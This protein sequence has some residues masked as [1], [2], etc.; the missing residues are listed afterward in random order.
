MPLQEV[1]IAITPRYTLTRRSSDYSVSINRVTLPHRHGTKGKYRCNVTFSSIL[2]FLSFPFLL[3][4]GF[5]S[6]LFF[7]S[8]WAKFP[9]IFSLSRPN[10]RS[11]ELYYFIEWRF[12]V[13]RRVV[14]CVAECGLLQNPGS[15]LHRRSGWSRNQIQFR[16][17]ITVSN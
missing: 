11:S 9:S 6:A 15:K 14:C 5:F 2:P 13:D 7:L 1:F 4:S 10:N 16:C 3:S 12:V 17:T 8:F